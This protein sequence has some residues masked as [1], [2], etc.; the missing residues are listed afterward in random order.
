[1]P[2]SG[3]CDEI[4]KQC[5][6]IATTSGVFKVR[7]AGRLRTAI[8]SSSQRT[9]FTYF[10]IEK[11][12]QV[13]TRVR[14][15]ARV[16]WLGGGRKIFGCHRSILPSFSKGKTKTKKFSFWPFTYFRGT[17]FALGWGH[18]IVCRGVA[19]SNGADLAS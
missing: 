9:V 10:P 2:S 16:A 12:L 6:G 15:G 5:S 11:N 1:M 17:S 14:P 8:V 18:V 7:P 19:E 3:V 4:V 13:R